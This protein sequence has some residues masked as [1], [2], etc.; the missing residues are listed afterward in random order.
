MTAKIHLRT[1]LE[2]VK[3]TTTEAYEHEIYP[4][5]AL[6]DDLNLP[7]DTSRNHLFDIIVNFVNFERSYIEMDKVKMT[8]FLEESMTSRADMAFYI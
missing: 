8:N 2:K 1:R 7:K 3:K 5:D 4:Y 6:V